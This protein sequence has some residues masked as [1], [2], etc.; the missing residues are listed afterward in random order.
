MR[1]TI[2]P[3]A[4]VVVVNASA[5]SR[6][7]AQNYANEGIPYQYR[8]E[9]SGESY[10]AVLLR[11]SATDLSQNFI[12]LEDT[13]RVRDMDDFRTGDPSAS[14]ATFVRSG[15]DVSSEELGVSL[16]AVRE[17]L[18]PSRGL[19]KFS[20]EGKT[21]TLVSCAGIFSERFRSDF[22]RLFAGSDG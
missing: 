2:L 18:D 14:L 8:V 17:E 21:Y 3:L 6:M 22:P 11:A 15:E 12:V 5:C 16:S 20:H 7:A 10:Y 4:L 1:L 9:V 13:Y 19:R